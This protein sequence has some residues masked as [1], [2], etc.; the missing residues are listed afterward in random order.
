MEVGAAMHNVADEKCGH[1]ACI[2]P[3]LRRGVL[4]GRVGRGGAKETDLMGA[5]VGAGGGG[6]DLVQSLRTARGVVELA[7][8][9]LHVGVRVGEGKSEG[10]ARE[11]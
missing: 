8:G 4:R 11:S 9:D 1:P 6:G 5:E 10:R 7:I 3:R 2:Y